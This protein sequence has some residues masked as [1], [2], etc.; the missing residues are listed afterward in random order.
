LGEVS[1]EI[2]TVPLFDVFIDLPPPPL[3]DIEIG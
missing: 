3:I 1:V 2:D